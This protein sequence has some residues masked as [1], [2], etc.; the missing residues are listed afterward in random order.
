M[1]KNNKMELSTMISLYAKY[2]EEMFANDVKNYEMIEKSLKKYEKVVFAL[3]S[4]SFSK[5][6]KIKAEYNKFAN[7]DTIEADISNLDDK[8][9]EMSSEMEMIHKCEWKRYKEN[10]MFIK[11]IAKNKTKEIGRMRYHK[12]H[13]DDIDDTDDKNNTNYD[14]N[15]GNNT[16]PYEQI[17]SRFRRAVNAMKLTN[18]YDHLSNLFSKI[19]QSN[20]QIDLEELDKLKKEYSVLKEKECGVKRELNNGKR[21]FK[22]FVNQYQDCRHYSPYY[23]HSNYVKMSAYRHAK[24]KAN[25]N[26]I[27]DEY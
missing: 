9:K 8:I 20:D 6:K 15:F 12:Y 19:M 2:I 10:Y 3:F 14:I 7:I 21:D 25:R 1:I 27:I 22:K 4:H 23:H 24:L 13:Y 16:F 18:K 17:L 5:Y 26:F 11:R